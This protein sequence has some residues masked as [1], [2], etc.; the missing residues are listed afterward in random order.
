[1]TIMV[2]NAWVCQPEPPAANASASAPAQGPEDAREESS[3]NDPLSPQAVEPEL[4][5][6]RPGIAL[7]RRF[8]QIAAETNLR[9]GLANTLLFQQAS[10]GPG[11]RWAAGG[12][13]DLFAKWIAI[14]AGTKD[15]GTLD[16]H[17]EYRY[18]IGDQPPAD[19]GADLGTLLKTTNGFGERPMIVKELY[20]DQRLFDEGFR[21]IVGRVNPEVLFGGH[22]LQSSEQYFLNQ[23]F[24]INPA[25][26]YPGPGL[27]VLA[28][29]NPSPWLHLHGGITDANGSATS[30]DFEEFFRV[31]EYLEFA[32]LAVTPEWAGVG[33]GRYRAALWHIDSREDAGR[34]EDQGFT[35]SADQEL[36]DA[37]IVFARYGHADGAVTQV[38]DSVQAGVAVKGILG[39]ENM[40]GAAAAWSAPKDDSK[41][42]EKTIE[43][44]QRFQVT[45]MI[46][47][48]LDA[49]A[50]FDPSNAPGDDVLGVFSARLRF[51]F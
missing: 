46:Q 42:D 10:A 25:V 4:R 50:I 32:E 3:P 6:I 51:S 36:G 12:D 34:P 18:Q 16:F 15:T 20:W 17:G 33:S 40:F 26:A 29:V 5:L 43:V 8:D 14:G 24:S 28:Q 9:L 37:V 41:R 45:E 47:F 22:K 2:D 44:F 13:L 30:N 19:L 23:A 31:R 1:M 49:Q 39:K 35:I 7:K 27:A 11:E 48:T 38:T 21:F